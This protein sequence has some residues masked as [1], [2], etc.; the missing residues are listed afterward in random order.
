M[1]VNGA[2]AIFHLLTVT[3]Q[4]ITPNV[5]FITCRAW[6]PLTVCFSCE[7]MAVLALNEK[8]QQ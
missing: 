4:F 7:V 6:V 5:S 3:F 8:S 2:P 1:G